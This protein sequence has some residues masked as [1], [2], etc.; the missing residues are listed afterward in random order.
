MAT[1]SR[2]DAADL[3]DRPAHVDLPDADSE[4]FATPEF[5]EDASG[6]AARPSREFSAYD[7]TIELNHEQAPRG[8]WLGLMVFVGVMVAIISAAAVVALEESGQPALADLARSAVQ[9]LPSVE[10]PSWEL[11]SFSAE[12]PAVP[13]RRAASVAAAPAP[14]V[15][16]S[17]EDANRLRPE[18]AQAEATPAAASA[19][20]V[21][22]PEIVMGPELETKKPEA[23][24]P[25]RGRRAIKARLAARRAAKLAAP[26]AVKAGPVAAAKAAP[27]ASAS[28][29]DDARE[30]ARQAY[31]A[32]RYGDAVKAY[33]QA[34]QANPGHALTLAGLGAARMQTGDLPGAVD[35]YQRAAKLAPDNASV[36]VALARACER[37]GDGA[38]A[39]ALY[40]RVLALDPE[41]PAARAAL[42]RL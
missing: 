25:Q 8:A 13:P 20:A 23:A 12:R 32:G 14:A 26:R 16:P 15:V 11:P 18:P 34:A 42:E 40:K 24:A 36:Q 19:P 38:R 35:A 29:W 4:F 28:A 41:H 22:L 17:A 5:H 30:A 33:E 10:L 6:V 31:A 7:E 21:T 9:A 27:K 37:S 3:Y 2:V 1:L 39:R